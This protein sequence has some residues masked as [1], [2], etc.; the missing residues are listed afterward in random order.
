LYGEPSVLYVVSY[1]PA[2]QVGPAHRP[3][4]GA[5]GADVPD[6]SVAVA[7]TEGPPIGACA[8]QLPAPSAITSA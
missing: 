5:D 3:A 7:T 2:M 6:E 4:T 8:N 1:W